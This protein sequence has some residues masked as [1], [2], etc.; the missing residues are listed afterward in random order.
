MG[1]RQPL[2]SHTHLTSLRPAGD[3]RLAEGAQ[4]LHLDSP[5]PGPS[6]CC[7]GGLGFLGSTGL[8]STRRRTLLLAQKG[9]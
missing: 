9:R 4:A 8:L 7:S 1:T 6:T 2:D 5:F 3:L